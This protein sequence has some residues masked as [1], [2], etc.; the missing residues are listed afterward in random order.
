M[1]NDYINVFNQ[2]LRNFSNPYRQRVKTEVANEHGY[3]CVHIFDW[4]NID[5]VISIINK[6]TIRVYGRNCNILEVNA[7]DA[8]AFFS[9][10]HLQST[11]RGILKCYALEYQGDIVQM[12]AFDKPRY[13]SN[14]DWELL[15]LCSKSGVSVIGGASKLYTHAKRNEVSNIISY[16][17][18]SKFN[19]NVYH[20]IGMKF[21]RKTKPSKV[22]SKGK[23]RI[24]S[25][26]LNNLG[27]DKIFGTDY[28]KYSNNEELM[29]KNG[30]LPVYDCGQLV[31]EDKE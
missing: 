30:W 23:N 4:D 16:C 2:K 3:R 25:N 10:N 22:W 24:T 21:L 11:C 8:N 31:F 9:E 1:H 27:Y 19:G 26:M 5:A 14:Y 20:N 18:Y 12:M 13:N 6:N 7:K 15:R 28:G 17:D 29:I